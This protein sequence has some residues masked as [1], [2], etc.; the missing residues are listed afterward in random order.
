V[1]KVALLG[2][3]TVGKSVAEL[4]LTRKLPGIVL[5]HIFNRN[6]A[7]KRAQASS[8]RVPES[9]I[10]TDNIEDVLGSDVDIVVELMGGL[11]PAERW[12]RRALASGKSVVTANKQL[13]AHQ[14]S[15]L[16]RLA[17]KNNAQLHYGAAVAGG[18]PVIPG[19][20]QGLG[21]DAITRVSGILN[22]T[23]NFI[24][25]KMEAGA[26]YAEVLAEAQ[27]LG[28]A[29]ANPSADVDGYDA[30]AKLVLLTRIALQ[31]E[32][33]PEAVV[34]QSIRSISA[35]DFSYAREMGCTIR[36]ISRAQLDG[37]LVRARVAP[38][39]VPRSMAIAGSHG[40]LNTVVTHGSF[41]GDV[42]FSG[43]GA[44]GHPT[45]V[46]VLSDILAVA[47]GNSQVA[48][49]V[50]KRQVTGEFVAPHYLRFVV[51]DKPGIVS[52]ISSALARYN[53]NLDTILQHTGFPKDRLPFI[54]T[55]EPC[56][57]TTLRKAVA[58]I[59]RMDSM[60]E[61]PL[62]LQ[63]LQVEDKDV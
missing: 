47:Q 2:Y 17:A 39:M 62:C 22:G 8:R 54:A 24:L 35:I 42:V 19:I 31:A 10:W 14:A 13:L 16:L 48:L 38:M 4:M 49:P 30:R 23:C 34:T 55:V 28:Y 37:S 6:I 56:L 18:V 63:I 60:L 5:T 36:Q 57:N 45:A 51:N 33:D 46:A 25:S 52:G 61:P 32:I 29:E 9:V 7:L 59:G 40:T 20:L 1:K 44:G 27:R 43:H 53:I 41:S 58:S 21:G 15:S 12:L 11:D 50:R 3:G 26:D